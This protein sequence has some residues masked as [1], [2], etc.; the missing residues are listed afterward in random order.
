MPLVLAAVLALTLNAQPLASDVDRSQA[1]T[2]FRL[3][4]EDLAGERFEQAIAS[5][6]K[7]VQKDPLLSI[8][9][10]GIGQAN[11]NLRRYASAIKAYSDCIDALRR[12]HELRQAG[13][14]EADKRR[15]DEIR[16]LREIVNHPGRLDRMKVLQVEQRLRDL[17]DQRHKPF[18]TFRPPAET[19]LALGSAQ[20]RN[21]DRDGAEANWKAAVEVN[22]KY[23]EAHNNLAV[24]YMQAGRLPEAEQELKLAEKNGFN[25]NPQFKSDLKERQKAATK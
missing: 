13:N 7:A 3:G 1:L 24:I 8:A 17:E 20:F 21:G 18:D 11:M 16:E 19:L 15:D 23:G 4:Q 9:H 25:V 6:T 5:F 10:Y 12:L 14:V 2:L 22:P